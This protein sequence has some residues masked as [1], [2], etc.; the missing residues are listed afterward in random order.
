MKPRKWNKIEGLLL[1]TAYYE[2]KDQSIKKQNEKAKELSCILRNFAIS[3][4]ENI[5][6]KFR[7]VDGVFMKMKNIEALLS[8]S[9]TGLSAISKNDIES[10]KYY[11]ENQEDCKKIYENFKRMYLN[12]E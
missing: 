10:N 2:V 11:L 4:N 9:K 3:N 5:D 6:E 12:E 1:V 7:N 8:N